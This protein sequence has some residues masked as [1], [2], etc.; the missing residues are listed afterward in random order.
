MSGYRVLF[1]CHF[2]LLQRTRDT[3]DGSLLALPSRGLLVKSPQPDDMLGSWVHFSLDAWLWKRKSWQSNFLE[4]SKICILFDESLGQF[5]RSVMYHSLQPHGLHYARLP[6]PSHTPGAYSNSCPLNYWCH[7]TISTTV[8]LFSSYL[9]SFPAS[10]FFQMGK[11]HIRWPKY[12][13][14]SFRINP[15]NEYLGLISFRIDR[16]DLLAVQ[17]TLKSLLQHHSSKASI[18]RCSAFFT[19]QLSHP[20]D[21]WKNHSLD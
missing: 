1:L 8:I 13:S 6:C 3:Q 19:V 17:R 11:D 7:P 2:Y 15:S 14:F 12:W 10:G 20:Y 21:H 5:K 18:L 9:K 16:L 4:R